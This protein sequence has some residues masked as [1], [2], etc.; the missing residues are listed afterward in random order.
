[1]SASLAAARRAAAVGSKSNNVQHGV[2][3]TAVRWFGMKQREITAVMD[4][5]LPPNYTLDSI[6]PPKY[7]G[8]PGEPT[9]DPNA[10]QRKAVTSAHAI[11]LSAN[12]P[13]LSARDSAAIGPSGAVVHGRY[14]ELG[15][16]ASG[17]PLEYL[18]L[19]RP[20]AEGAAAVRLVCEASK[21]NGT[22]TLLVYGA[23][24][25]NALAAVQL[26][27]SSGMAVVAVVGGEGSGDDEMMDIVKGLA[28]EPGTAVPEEYALVKRNFRDLVQATVHGE[29]LGTSPQ[30]ADAMLAEF[31]ANLLDYATTF[32]D[33]LPA[34]VSPDM[35][36]LDVTARDRDNYRS[37][38]E[39]YLSQFTAG[40]PPINKQL[41]EAYFTKEHYATFKTKFGT[42]TT[43]VISGSQD[44]AKE[45]NPAAIVRSMLDDPAYPL[46]EEATA[47]EEVEGAGPFV[48]YY[49]SVLD[50]TKIQKG[51]EIKKGGPIAGAI[52]AVTPDLQV[53][54]TALDKAGPSLRAKAEAL[55]FLTDAQRNAFAAASSVATIAKEAGGSIYVVG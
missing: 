50:S 8:S 12:P 27:S 54:A 34:A 26:A 49:F 48:P 25:P 15:E 38:M 22:G 7:W 53:A 44:A 10:Y 13:K 21:T 47:Q 4:E 46:D 28:Q 30:D 51:L 9:P 55:Q 29:D 20:A 36:T 18:A 52:I 23:T 43:A 24:Q 45:F 37:N 42:Q 16:A 40:S 6:R 17:I 2:R 35:L 41:L 14:G 32:P 11:D 5:P 39:E 31:K 33:S 3:K 19:L 1:M